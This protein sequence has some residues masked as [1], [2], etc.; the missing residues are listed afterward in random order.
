MLYRDLNAKVSLTVSYIIPL[1][2]CPNICQN[3]RLHLCEGSLIDGRRNLLVNFE[4]R[5]LIF[6]QFSDRIRNLLLK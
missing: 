6:V 5:R 3:S 1:L 4:V 2:I